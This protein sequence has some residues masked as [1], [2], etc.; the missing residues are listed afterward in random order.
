MKKIILLSI[1]MLG[2]CAQV[3]TDWAAATKVI[4][5]IE[6]TKAP[7]LAQ[8]YELRAGYDAAFLAPAANYRR[9]GDCAVGVAS[10]LA[11]PC[12]EPKIVAK[13]KAI[14]KQAVAALDS[15][16]VFTRDHPGDLGINGLYDAAKLAIAQAMQVLAATK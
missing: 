3:S 16:E 6:R 11:V 8:V 7:T 15:L 10:T 13:L 14:D 12:A 9:L 1:L 4:G 5:A 2:G